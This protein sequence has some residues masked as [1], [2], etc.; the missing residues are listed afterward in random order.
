MQSVPHMI[1]NAFGIVNVD[2]ISEAKLTSMH[3]IGAGMKWER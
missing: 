1:S 2:D 3:V